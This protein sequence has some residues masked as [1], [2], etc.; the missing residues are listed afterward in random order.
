MLSVVHFFKISPQDC[1]VVQWL[2]LCSQCRAQVWS[3][4][5]NYKIPCAMWRGPTTTNQ[6]SY[7]SLWIITKVQILFHM[8]TLF[9]FK[10]KFFLPR[11]W[12]WRMLWNTELGKLG[13]M[14]I[15]YM[16]ISQD[17]RLEVSCKLWLAK[18]SMISKFL[19]LSCGYKPHTFFR[20]R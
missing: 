12:V 3:W 18:I 8:L 2:R 15:S 6:P 11:I 7:T 1:P 16:L 14:I 9:L 5:G 19:L 4:L 10:I 20:K 17:D 13:C